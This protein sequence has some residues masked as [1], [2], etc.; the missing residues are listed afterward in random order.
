MRHGRHKPAALG[1]AGGFIVSETQS[2][3]A[4]EAHGPGQVVILASG[5]QQERVVH[6]TTV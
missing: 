4:A 3:I 2:V 1:V 5:A 6:K